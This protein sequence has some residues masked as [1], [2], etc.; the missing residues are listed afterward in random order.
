MGWSNWEELG[1]VLSSAPSVS[2]WGS[3]RLDVFARGPEGALWHQW[4]EKSWKGWESLGMPMIGP[5]KDAPSAVSWSSP[6]VGT[7]SNG[8]SHQVDPPTVQ[9]L[10]SQPETR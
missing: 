10:D 2:S 7:A 9:P 6:S 3:K 1:G 8:E 4:F 5:N